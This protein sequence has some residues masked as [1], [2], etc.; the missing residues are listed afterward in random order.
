MLRLEAGFVQE[1]LETGESG[2]AAFEDVGA[3]VREA[4][5]RDLFADVHDFRFA[6]HSD[7]GVRR[8][9]VVRGVV[10]VKGGADVCRQRA[11]AAQDVAEP[12]RIRVQRDRPS[13]ARL[14][15][16]RVQNAIQRLR[17]AAGLEIKTHDVDL[18]LRMLALQQRRDR[19]LLLQIA[20][21]TQPNVVAVLQLQVI[22][23]PQQHR[24]AHDRDHR[25][26]QSVPAFDVG[27]RLQTAHRH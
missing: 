4:R 25:L 10:E 8:V 5:D 15:V 27:V 2:V 19:K 1:T 7:V 6:V 22:E 3:V 18:Q 9:R 17:D 20:P 24:P 11:R 16:H 21:Q 14:G 23:H 26:R 13:C 12:Q